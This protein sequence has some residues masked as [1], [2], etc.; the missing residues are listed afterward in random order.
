ML[1]VIEKPKTDLRSKFIPVI[2]ANGVDDDLPGFVAAAQN[3]VVLF[4][5]DV[6]QPSQGIVI[7]GRHLVFGKKLCVVG[8]EDDIPEG[9]RAERDRWEIVVQPKGAR[10]IAIHSCFLDIRHG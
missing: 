8:A 9:I 5:E 2:F 4:D 6:Y 7:F 10:R 1:D 3:N